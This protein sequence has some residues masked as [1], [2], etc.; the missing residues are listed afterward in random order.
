MTKEYKQIFAGL[1]FLLGLACIVFYAFSH[2]MDSRTAQDVRMIAHGHLQGIM[3][4]EASRFEAIKAIRRTQV[5]S[6]RATLQELEIEADSNT[7]KSAIIRASLFQNLA[8]C[9]LL[10]A[11]GNLSTVYGSPLLKL[12]D[13]DFLL[14]GILGGRQ[15]VTG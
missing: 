5:D 4:Q 8:N 7:V 3:E 11:E 1:F 13:P 6:L 15:I 9:S 2:Y 10:D 14:K 12:G